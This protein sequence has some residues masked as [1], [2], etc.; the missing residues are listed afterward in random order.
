L[1]GSHQLVFALFDAEVDGAEVWT[2]THGLDLDAGY[3]SVVLGNQAPLH[4]GLFSQTPLWLQLTVDGDL[5]SPRRE[6]NSVPWSLRANVAQDV[7]GGTVNASS[8]SVNGQVVVDGSG[9]W[10]GTPPGVSWS[11]VTNVPPDLRDGD[12]DILDSLSCLPGE[13]PR[14]Q[15]LTGQWICSPDQDTDT[16]TDTLATLACGNDELARWTGSNWVC[17]ADQN[18]DTLATLSCASSEVAQWN[19]SAWSCGPAASPSWVVNVRDHGAQGDG[20]T[21][22]TAA[23][24]AALDAVPTNGGTVIVPPGKYMVSE[25]LVV[26]VA[27]T[28][29]SGTTMGYSVATGATVSGT[30]IQALPGFSG[31]ALVQLGIPGV[32]TRQRLIIEK[33]FLHCQDQAMDGIRILRSNNPLMIRDMSIFNCKGYGIYSPWREI[34]PDPS[35]P[36]NAQLVAGRIRNVYVRNC[37]TGLRLYQTN[38]SVVENSAFVN[39]DHRAVEIVN[40]NNNT[41]ANVLFEASFEQGLV[42][43]GTGG[44]LWAESVL[45][46]N[47]RFEHNNRDGVSREALLVGPLVRGLVVNSGRFQMDDV[48]IRIQGDNVSVIGGEFHQNLVQ[49][50]IVIE[51]TADDS[52]ILN[53]KGTDEDPATPLKPIQ[54]SGDRTTLIGYGSGHSFRGAGAVEVLQVDVDTERVGVGLASP[55]HTLDVAG[56]VRA[57]G[58]FVFPDGSSQATASSMPSG[59]IGFFD[60]PSCPPGWSDAIDAQGRI[61]VGISHLDALAGTVGTPLGDLE[62]RAH[63][64]DLSGIDL[65]ESLQAGSHEHAYSGTT[66]AD[67]SPIVGA[68]P[69]LPASSY[70][71]HSH[72]YSGTTDSDGSH[73][74]GMTTSAGTSGS[75]AASSVL[76]YIQYMVCSKD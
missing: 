18:S 46:E 59:L 43:E 74:H 62:D 42:V 5:L 1:S 20:I 75:V 73:S 10:L 58:G 40:G 9:S 19:G 41:L 27:G 8:L 23:I 17:S 7:D 6:L 64:H 67:N 31:D 54:D 11:D 68:G 36:Q 52:L 33:L 53:P 72:T 69:G 3:Y 45:V 14:Y 66:H 38:S 2:E 44:G 70:T 49:N 28:V 25:P 29:F 61:V 37:G 55:Q 35:D 76:P 15:G 4:D 50:S 32:Y 12:S 24:Q 21:D 26:T 71:G 30:A 16:D 65:G 34:E 48:G 56:E 22:D 60:L 63:G 39:S 47:G 57:S 13:I 51:S